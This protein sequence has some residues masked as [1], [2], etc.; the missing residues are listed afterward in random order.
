MRKLRLR[1][2]LSLLLILAI[3]GYFQIFSKYV[4]NSTFSVH[5]SVCSLSRILSKPGVTGCFFISQL[6]KY[7]TVY[8]KLYK[9]YTCVCGIKYKCS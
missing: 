8:L 4:M 1:A 7:S 6:Q 9:V 2:L 3:F 5:T